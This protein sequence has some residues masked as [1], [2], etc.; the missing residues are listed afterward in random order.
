ML[1]T[2]NHYLPTKRFGILVGMGRANQF[3]K[4]AFLRNVKRYGI[5]FFGEIGRRIYFLK[6]KYQSTQ[7][8]FFKEHLLKD[9]NN[10]PFRAFSLIW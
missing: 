10:P 7:A 5:L 8:N 2:I 6:S 4:L 9:E 3:G 1:A